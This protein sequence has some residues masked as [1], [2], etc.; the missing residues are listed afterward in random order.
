[1]SIALFILTVL[2]TALFWRR[3]VALAEIG[4]P[5]MDRVA[6]A[7]IESFPCSDAPAWTL[8]MEPHAADPE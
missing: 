4:A 2:V 6:E 7:S 8:G 3:I 5:V 1:M